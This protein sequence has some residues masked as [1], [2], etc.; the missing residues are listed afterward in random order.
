[1]KIA[2]FVLASASLLAAQVP[3]TVPQLAPPPP[4]KGPILAA[5]PPTAP[6]PP[7]IYVEGLNAVN[8]AEW[9]K[10]AADMK[11]AQAAMVKDRADGALYWQ[12]Y[13]EAKLKDAQ[14]AIDHLRQLRKDYPN[15]DWA[16]DAKALELQI[17]HRD[18]PGRL[19]ILRDRLQPA[20]LE[21]GD[22]LKLLA[23]NGLMQNDPKQA[24]PVLEKV[25][26]STDSSA[27]KQRALF[28]LAQS[29]TPEASAAIAQFAA[30][31]S[32]PELRRAA[33]ESLMM[34]GND[35]A[36]I[37]LARKETNPDLK[38]QIVEELSNMHTKAATQYLIE[39]LNN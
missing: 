6:T 5:T 36:L 17:Q 27:V 12:A 34:S 8:Q 28:V 37:A 21:P 31:A 22:D 25:L 38:R 23:I 1:M 4:P 7:P 3:Q 9:A 20:K 24:L 33:I 26:A 19:M 14:A 11:A 15:S 35:T 29:H 39:I 18:M 13:S 30:S 16:P 2:L 10:A 32:Q